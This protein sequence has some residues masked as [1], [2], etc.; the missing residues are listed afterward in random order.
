M[1]AYTFPTTVPGPSYPIE[2]QAEPR[3]KRVSF[4]DGYTQ[5]A[6]DGL[7]YNLYTWNLSWD[8]LTP[9]EKT[10]IEN[11]LIARGGYQSFNWTDPTGTSFVVKAP[12]WT[13]SNFEPSI[14]KITATFKQSPL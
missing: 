12:T 3:V 6:P 9:A 10:T 4:G 8:A 5:E 2:K 14:Y 11:F 1:A 7:N 13:V